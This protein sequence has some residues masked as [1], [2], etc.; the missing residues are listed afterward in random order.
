M[1]T[2]DLYIR[3]SRGRDDERAHSPEQQ[4][5]IARRGLP[6]GVTVGEV[7]RDFDQSGGT[8][9]RP[10]LERALARIELGESKGIVVARLDRFGRTVR[11]IYETVDRIHDAGAQ[12]ISV[13]DNFDLTTR[14]GRL[15][16]G[17][18]S[19]MADWQLDGIKEQWIGVHE[20]NVSDGIPTRVPF[21]YQRGA[22]RRLVI[23]PVGAAVVR[24]IYERVASGQGFGAVANWLNDTGKVT[25]QGGR[26]SPRTIGVIVRN[27]AYLGEVRYGELVNDQAHEALVSE[28]AFQEANAARAASAPRGEADGLL[29][30]LV[31]C[32]NCRYRMVYAKGSATVAPYYRCERRHGAGVC[33]GPVRVPAAELHAH[34]LAWRSRV[35]EEER[36]AVGEVASDDDLLM[37]EAELATAREARKLFQED[38][39]LISVLGQE[40]Y[41]KQ[42][43]RH[44]EREAELE[45]KLGELMTARRLTPNDDLEHL[46]DRPLVERRLVLSH[47]IDCIFVRGRPGQGRH[48]RRMPIGGR[49]LVL[50]RGEGP[51]IEQLPRRGGSSYVI[52]AF[53]FPQDHQPVA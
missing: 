14:T 40:E 3:R 30:G 50:A 1:T 23:E 2:M 27:R 51:E 35:V 48:R 22:D 16:F 24:S 34:V 10:G 11:G 32:A 53:P 12:L 38:L 45:E 26:F 47:G 17:M 42:L 13:E 46:D 33:P 21:G 41:R 44:M 6:D 43:K 7:I 31:R 15:M 5:A 9:N 4:E 18:L 25:R 39:E 36:L 52:A 37:V 28:R 19:L 20:K 29:T 49:V 8:M